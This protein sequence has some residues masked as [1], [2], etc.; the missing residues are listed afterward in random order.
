M[1]TYKPNEST[2]VLQYGLLI[3]VW[4]RYLEWCRCENLMF[5][6]HCTYVGLLSCILQSIRWLCWLIHKW[7][8]L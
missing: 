1:Y 6:L 2:D 8:R 5:V 3:S 7:R 4:V